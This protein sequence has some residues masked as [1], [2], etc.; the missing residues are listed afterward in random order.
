MTT[1]TDTGIDSST[2][3]GSVSLSDALAS[4]A[5]SA[6][7]VREQAIRTELA[8]NPQAWRALDR[9]SANLNC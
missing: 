2:G 8:N 6:S 5:Q 3:A 1:G 7:R 9:R 4:E